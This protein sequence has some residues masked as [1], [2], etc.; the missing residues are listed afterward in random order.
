[1]QAGCSGRQ[2]SGKVSVNARKWGIELRDLNPKTSYYGRQNNK[3]HDFGDQ[4]H[5]H[6]LGLFVCFIQ[7]EREGWRAERE[8]GGRE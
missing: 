5:G 1:M 2:Q 7:Y 3:F 4:V 6:M 8:R